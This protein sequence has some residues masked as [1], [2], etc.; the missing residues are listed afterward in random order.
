MKFFLLILLAFSI[1]LAQETEI[2]KKLL[3]STTFKETTV[4]FGTGGTVTLIGAPSGSIE[5]KGWGENQIKIEAKIE[6]QA[7]NE[8]DIAQIASISGF[9][10]D[11]DITH[12]R[13]ISVGNYDKDYV[14]RVAKKFPKRLLQ[15]PLRIDYVITVPAYCDLEINGGKGDFSIEGVE[16]SL[17]IRFIESK[18]K[19]DV[20]GGAVDATF[21]SG[22]VEIN[23]LSPSWRGRWLSVGL[24]KGNM[25]ITLPQLMNAEMNASILQSGEI[26]NFLSS[27]R[28]SRN[29]NQQSGKTLNTK[30]GNGGASLT[31]RVGNGTIKIL[32]AK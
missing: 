24:A 1:S 10:I 31:F 6:I 9:L 26:Q 5:V 25:K 19:L 16:G 8:N 17:S 30:L 2:E 18:A 22:D 11:K 4:E 21:G 13:I 14:K 7:E 32:E 20:S 15:M 23:V 27:L 12:V 29:S 3:K 28:L